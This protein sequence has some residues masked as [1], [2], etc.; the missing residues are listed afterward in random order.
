MVA[1]RKGVGRTG[2]K[3]KDISWANANS[4]LMLIN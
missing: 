2:M 3:R 1:K 4:L